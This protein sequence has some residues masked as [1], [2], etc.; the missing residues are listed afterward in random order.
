M[1]KKRLLVR[2]GERNVMWRE[3]IRHGNGPKMIPGART[4]QAY[5]THEITGLK[6][7]I[8]CFYGISRA[9]VANVF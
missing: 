6:N 4:A 2:I 7:A 5:F 1:W 9:N 8:I 3:G